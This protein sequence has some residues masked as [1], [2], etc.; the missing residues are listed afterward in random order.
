MLIHVATELGLNAPSGKLADVEVVFEAKDCKL[1]AGLSL[2]GFTVWES[3]FGG[4][5]VTLPAR[6]YTVGG[7]K[8][9][10]ALLRDHDGGSSEPLKTAIQEA[11][12]HAVKAPRLV[13]SNGDNEISEEIGA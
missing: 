10:Y 11:Y 12:R 4:L 3:R 13:K 5:N 6:T 7:Q 1:L 2:Q 9:S 8:R